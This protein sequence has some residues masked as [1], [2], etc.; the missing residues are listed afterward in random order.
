MRPKKVIFHILGDRTKR[1]G[2]SLHVSYDRKGYD[3]LGLTS[4]AVNEM[5]R[6]LCSSPSASRLLMIVGITPTKAHLAHVAFRLN[7]HFSVRRFGAWS[8][9]RAFASAAD[10]SALGSSFST[11]D[12]KKER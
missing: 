11:N 6:W 4:R 1:S 5:R 7:N 2:T 3:K 12:W 8:L 9:S 10:G